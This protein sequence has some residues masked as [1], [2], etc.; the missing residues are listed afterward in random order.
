MTW[1]RRSTDRPCAVYVVDEEGSEYVKVGITT[2]PQTALAQ[3][4]RGNPLDLSFYRLI[5]FDSETEA[6]AVEQATH[7]AMARWKA[8]SRRSRE[9]FAR[10]PEQAVAEVRRQAGM[11]RSVVRRRIVAPV[12][13]A[14]ARAADWLRVAAE[15]VR[16]IFACIG[17]GWTAWVVYGWHIAG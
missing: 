13:F 10:T 5:W 1:F 15:T 6:Y 12:R 14:A 17:V 2:S 3:L 8:P 9:W 4:Q 16:W 11:R 7:K